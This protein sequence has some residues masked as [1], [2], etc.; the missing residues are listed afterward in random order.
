MFTVVKPLS[1]KSLVILLI[2]L[3]SFDVIFESRKWPGLFDLWYS[4]W[5][6]SKEAETQSSDNGN[7]YIKESVKTS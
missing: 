7:K 5:F 6:T 4:D 3:S 2:I 1:D